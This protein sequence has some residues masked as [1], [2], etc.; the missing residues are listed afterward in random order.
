M[1]IKEKKN[2]VVN[3]ERY[4]YDRGEGSEGLLFIGLRLE[5]NK[6]CEE[7]IGLM[8]KKVGECYSII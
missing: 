3:P 8:E 4:L 2:A 7:N 5:G 1:R 6:E